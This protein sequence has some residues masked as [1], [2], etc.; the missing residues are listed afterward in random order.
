[1]IYKL[2][3]DRSRF[4]SFDISPDVL[5]ES[6]GPDYFSLLEQPQWKS[7]WQPLPVEFFD[8]SDKHDVTKPPDITLWF[9]DQLV[10]NQKAYEALNDTLSSYGEWLPLQCEGLPYWL[11]HITRTTGMDAVDSAS[12]RRVEESGYI[13]VKKLQFNPSAVKDLLLFKSEFDDGKNIFCSDEYRTL[14]EEHGLQGLVFSK[15]LASI[16]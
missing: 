9:T 8:D 15:D 3:F 11:L 7:F 6:F 10:V 2:R 13:D 1:M 4:L 12:V 14:I 5:E 16:F